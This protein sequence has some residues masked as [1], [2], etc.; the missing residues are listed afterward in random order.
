LFA[1]R[2]RQLPQSRRRV[3]GPCPRR[4]KELPRRDILRLD[5]W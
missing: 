4:G 5:L 2:D 1:H 3:T